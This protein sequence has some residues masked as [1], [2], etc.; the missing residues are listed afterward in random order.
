MF[1]N[2]PLIKK[3]EKFQRKT[4]QIVTPSRNQSQAKTFSRPLQTK[5]PDDGSKRCIYD[6]AEVRALYKKIAVEHAG[7]KGSIILDDA[8]PQRCKPE[9]AVDD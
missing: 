8:M 5:E 1:S 6:G 9:Q 4:V 2:L 7:E 3:S